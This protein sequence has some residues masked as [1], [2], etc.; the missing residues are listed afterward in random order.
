MAFGS[1]QSGQPGSIR[2]DANWDSPMDFE[3]TRE[4]FCH[5]EAKLTRIAGTNK[6]VRNLE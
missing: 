3:R 4:T 5:S 1:A 6:F 2:W